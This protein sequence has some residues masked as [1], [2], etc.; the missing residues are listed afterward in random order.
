[1]MAHHDEDMQK[2]ERALTEAHRARQEPPLGSDWARLVMRDIRHAATREGRR[3]MV[4]GVEQLV[5]RTAAVAATV[6]VILTVSIL[7]LSPTGSTE[8]AGSV[9]EEFE[10]ALLFPE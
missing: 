6:T 7:A 9:A 2:L 8:S 4:P 10:L 1:M 3:S 5:W